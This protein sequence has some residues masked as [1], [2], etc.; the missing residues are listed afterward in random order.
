MR[1]EDAKPDEIAVNQE[2]EED[3][4]SSSSSVPSGNAPITVV[5]EAP[6]PEPAH[7]AE[8]EDKR[9]ADATPDIVLDSN[10]ESKSSDSEDPNNGTAIRIPGRRFR[11]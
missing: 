9:R 4:K 3:S 6:G 8:F 5:E 10:G 2:E 7:S 11:D 1:Q